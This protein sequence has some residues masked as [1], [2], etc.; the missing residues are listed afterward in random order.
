MNQASRPVY[1]RLRDEICAAIL[2]G[3]YPEGAMLPSVRAYAAQQG[4]N[5]LTV[6]KAYQQFQDEGLV[7][8][9][10]GIGMFVAP[11]A[12]AALRSRE[13]EVFVREEWPEI[14]KRMQLLGLTLRDVTEKA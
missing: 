4:A 13:R 5:P 8:V 14:A 11:G 6:A 2:D 3:Q 9:Q 7:T 1:L 10:R 12:V